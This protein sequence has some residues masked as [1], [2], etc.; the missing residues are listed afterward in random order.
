MEMGQTNKTDGLAIDAMR[1]DFPIPV[2]CG[3][4]HR[5]RDRVRAAEL[6]Q[7]VLC[8]VNS[9]LPMGDYDWE[10]M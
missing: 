8:N 2:V 5:G 9:V 1:W 10:D 3:T 7:N 4:Q 6:Q